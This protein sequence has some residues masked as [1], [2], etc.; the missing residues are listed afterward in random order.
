MC[1]LLSPP[2][3]ELPSLMGDAWTKGAHLGL[4]ASTGELSDN[5][6]VIR[7]ETYI[8]STAAERGEKQREQKR[9]VEVEPVTM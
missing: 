8:S 4:T 9:P 5:H 2:K 3:I 1:I 6:D 7:L